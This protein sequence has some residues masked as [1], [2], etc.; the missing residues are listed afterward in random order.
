MIMD[1]YASKQ[2]L[3]GI[4]DHNSGF[5]LKGVLKTRVTRDPSPPTRTVMSRKK[6]K[7]RERQRE[8]QRERERE[9]LCVCMS[10]CWVG[11][12]QFRICFPCVQTA[13]ATT[14]A[15]PL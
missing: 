14:T 7:K 6:E 12:Q 2:Q 4:S 11:G 1:Y 13:R 9:S 15:W 8:R 5:S 3:Q 10:V